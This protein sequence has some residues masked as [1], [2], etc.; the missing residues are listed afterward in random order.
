[1]ISQSVMNLR[2]LVLI[3]QTILDNRQLFRMPILAEKLLKIEQY[4]WGRKSFSLTGEA[5]EKYISALR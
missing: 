5:R 4:N 1:M 2:A 3:M